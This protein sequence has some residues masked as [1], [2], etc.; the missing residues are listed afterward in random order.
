MK[1]F[2]SWSMQRSE[3]LASALADWLPSV[4]QDVEPFVSQSMAP[5]T[6]WTQE[7][8]KQLAE[9]TFAVVC[10][11]PENLSSPWLNYEMGA[12]AE[13][14][15]GRVA[16][17]LLDVSHDRLLGYPA[18]FL[19]ACSVNREGAF[20]L[21]IS[22][23]TW[24]KKPLAEKR[25]L[26]GFEQNWPAL[27]SLVAAIPEQQSPTIRF[28]E[29]LDHLEGLLW[30]AVKPIERWDSKFHDDYEASR[31]RKSNK[32]RSNEEEINEEDISEEDISEDEIRAGTEGMERNIVKSESPYADDE[33]THLKRI[34]GGE[35]GGSTET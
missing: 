1:V 7:L 31:G 13:R 18:G 15:E 25:L 19:Q 34:I 4:I 9:S 16:P 12:L 20:A 26:Q 17:W 22:I 27:E 21:V 8:R 5:G 24:V 10:L 14:L 3:K 32:A 30:R 28:D 35:L 23:N 29:R 11:T 2:V 6:F 33:P